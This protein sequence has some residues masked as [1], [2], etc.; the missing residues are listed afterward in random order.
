MSKRIKLSVFFAVFL[1]L[2]YFLCGCSKSAT[3]TG[4]PGTEF[5][6]PKPSGNIFFMTRSPS[7]ILRFAGSN[8]QLDTVAMPP[9]NIQDFSVSRSGKT[10]AYKSGDSSITVLNLNNNIEEIFNTPYPVSGKLSLHP[11]ANI[12]MF[13]SRQENVTFI[14]QLF[15]SSG[16]VLEW[17]N[18]N[19]GHSGNPLYSRGGSVFAWRQPNGLYI[20]RI[21]DG[22]PIHISDSVLVPVDFSPSAA[23]LATETKIFDLN[24]NSPTLLDYRGAVRFID[25]LTL[26]YHRQLDNFIYRTN[27]N[28]TDHEVLLGPLVRDTPFNTSPDGRYLAWFTGSAGVSRLFYYN[29][30]DSRADTVEFDLGGS[31]VR[32]MIW[33]DGAIVP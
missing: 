20:A 23:Y 30:F 11:S 14:A 22:Q 12:L 21:N 7:V 32:K 33:R 6:L 31:S 10:L 13:E 16:D 18:I 2:G 8:N 27:V 19:E 29:L 24:R 28:G 17:T 25:N 26:L 9:V 3:E 1:L 5:E 15:F 4:G